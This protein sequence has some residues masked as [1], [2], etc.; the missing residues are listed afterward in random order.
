M[1][2]DG[3]PNVTQ[4]EQAAQRERAVEV[5]L[6][7]QLA[8]VRDR[9]LERF[10]DAAAGDAGG[11]EARADR[12]ELTLLATPAR[13]VELLAFCRDDEH[14][15]CELLSDL[16]GVHWPGGRVEAAVE[17]TTGWPTYAE[18][19]EGAIE[20]SYLLT[21]ITHGHRFRVRVSVGD[22]EPRLPSAVDV[23]RSARVME[24]E[25]YDFFGVVFE[26]HG[27]LERILMPEDWVGHPHRKDYPLGGVE[28]EY[29]G[30]TIPPPDERDY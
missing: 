12:G 17:E 29:E 21:S 10:G 8:F 18:E 27:R 25:A 24:R 14:I 6:S 20:I 4:G 7:E 28:V 1:S 2:R 22:E 30:A 9:L 3:N 15:R 19:R 5:A 13:L 23:Y 11:L 16:S 26:G